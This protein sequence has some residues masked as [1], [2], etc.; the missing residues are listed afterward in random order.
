MSKLQKPSAL[1]REHSVL[2]KI[3]FINCFLFFWAIFALLDPDPYYE[4]ES[5]YGA[6]NPM[7]SGSSPDSDTD[8]DPQH[9]VLVTEVNITL[10]QIGYKSGCS[11]FNN[12]C[13][14]GIKKCRSITSK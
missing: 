14:F 10:G 3:K 7:E 1:K 6:K 2:Q 4:S 5:G 12:T 11:L 9:W 13:S 8:P